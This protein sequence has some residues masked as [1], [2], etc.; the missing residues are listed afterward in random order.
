[1][2]KDHFTLIELLVIRNKH[3]CL[4][5]N[6]NNTSLR[7]DGR[8]SRLLKASSSH[9]HAPK[10]FFTRSAFTLI[11]LLV[12]IAMM[13]IHPRSKYSFF[14]CYFLPFKWFYGLRRKSITLKNEILQFSIYFCN[15]KA[16]VL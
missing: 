11:E 15:R 5:E 4:S 7:P 2:R 6:K 14:F 10:A 3:L 9:L 8:T 16:S 1:M 13:A 12:V